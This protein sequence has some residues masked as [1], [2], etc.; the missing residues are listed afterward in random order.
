M[1]DKKVRHLGHDI[2]IK[3]ICMSGNPLQACRES[4]T[5]KNINYIKWL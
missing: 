1:M 2:K 3:L 4:L 5:I